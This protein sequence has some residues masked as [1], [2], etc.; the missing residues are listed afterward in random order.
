[1][2]KDLPK[3]HQEGLRQGYGPYRSVEIS[4]LDAFPFGRGPDA[5][6]I[7]ERAQEENHAVKGEIAV[8]IDLLEIPLTGNHSDRKANEVQRRERNHIGP[9]EGVADLSVERIG[10]VFVESQDVGRGFD[11]G[12]LAENSRNPG[13]R[14]NDRKPKH[15]SHTRPVLEE[16]EGERSGSEKEYPDPDRPVGQTVDL[17]VLF[18]DLNMLANVLNPNGKRH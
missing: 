8:L 14:E 13:A 3:R 6:Q 4:P 7:S 9:G 16:G 10:T 1:M 17:F 2:R 5:R 11:S 18:A 15:I 12:Q